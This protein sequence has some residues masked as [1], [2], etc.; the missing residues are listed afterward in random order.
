MKRCERCIMPETVPGVT[1][2][3]DGICSYCLDYTPEQSLGQEAF[4][5]IVA[6]A[7]SRNNE[8][9]CIVPLSGG[10]D[11]TFILHLAKAVYGLK[12]LAVNYD[13]EFRNEQALVNMTTACKVLGVDFISVRSKRNLAS[14]IVLEAIPR[15]VPDGLYQICKVLCAAC[16]YGY[17]SVS[18]R[19]AHKH[20]A[21]LI[22][23]GFSQ[24]ERT[25]NMER[26][27][28]E[29][30]KRLTR[31]Q[32]IARFYKIMY[33]KLL[34]KMEFPV[35]GNSVLA[36]WRL[37]TI[38]DKN[39]KEICVFDYVPWNR[40]Q[41]KETIMTEL[42][43]RV[44]SGHVSSWRFDCALHALVNYCYL[45]LFGCTKDCFGYCG[46]INSGQMSRSDALTQEE[47]QAVM[48]RGNIRQLL[49][50]EIG[51]A[52]Q[53]AARIESLGAGSEAF[54]EVVRSK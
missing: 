19:A 28:A 33:Y 29:G 51:L 53:Q 52:K 24:A 44:P 30:F 20:K 34:Q 3:K 7:R 16:V 54:Q 37:P 48:L 4:Q 31:P 8:Y 13:N 35:P 18:C 2:N 9:D 47:Q 46:M 25:Q 36:R 12:V 42:G 40:E 50:G 39:I 32:R 6:S 5:E 22:L 1:F 21:P 41:I 43:W 10:R 23:W 27:A 38:K 45:G 49:E 14:K 11:S 17:R 26:K 15:A